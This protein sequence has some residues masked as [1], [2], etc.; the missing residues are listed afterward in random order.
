MM[1]SACC[2]NS[3]FISARLFFTAAPLTIEFPLLSQ[4]SPQK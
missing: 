1:P 3:T 4:I 2:I